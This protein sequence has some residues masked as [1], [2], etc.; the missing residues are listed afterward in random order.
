MKS[1]ELKT[2]DTQMTSLVMNGREIDLLLRKNIL[3]AY[4]DNF[5]GEDLLSSIKEIKN[6][7]SSDSE[8]VQ[9]ELFLF[10]KL[11][12]LRS[13]ILRVNDFYIQ[14]ENLDIN[15]LKNTLTNYSKAISNYNNNKKTPLIAKDF[16]GVS[17]SLTNI[18]NIFSVDNNFDFKDVYQQIVTAKVTMDKALSFYQD[19]NSGSINELRAIIN[20]AEDF[21]IQLFLFK[22]KD[23]EKLVKDIYSSNIFSAYLLEKAGFAPEEKKEIYASEKQ[24]SILLWI[25]KSYLNGENYETGLQELCA[26]NAE[27]Y[28]LLANYIPVDT[29]FNETS[30]TQFSKLQHLVLKINQSISCLYKDNFL[31]KNG[32]YIKQAI[33]VASKDFAYQRYNS[34]GKKEKTQKYLE[35]LRNLLSKKEEVSS[36]IG[37]YKKNESITEEELTELRGFYH[38]SESTLKIKQKE[39]KKDNNAELNIQT[40]IDFSSETISLIP[41]ILSGHMLLGFFQDDFVQFMDSINLDLG[42]IKLIFDNIINPVEPPEGVLD[43][44]KSDLGKEVLNNMEERVKDIDLDSDSFLANFLQCMDFT[45]ESITDLSAACGEEGIRTCL[46]AIICCT[47]SCFCGVCSFCCSCYF[48]RKL[49]KETKKDLRYSKELIINLREK[50]NSNLLNSFGNKHQDAPM[51]FWSMGD[52]KKEADASNNK[53]YFKISSIT[54]LIDYFN[55]GYVKSIG[56]EEIFFLD[57]Y[58]NRP[59]ELYFSKHS[60]DA[61]FDSMS[62][63]IQNH[64]INKIENIFRKGNSESDSESKIHNV[65][66]KYFNAESVDLIKMNYANDSV[67]HT[68]LT[69]HIYN[70]SFSGESTKSSN[71]DKDAAE[72]MAELLKNLNIFLKSYKDTRLIHDKMKDLT[73]LLKYRK[74]LSSDF[75]IGRNEHFVTQDINDVYGISCN[76][77]DNPEEKPLENLEN[78]ITPDNHSIYKSNSHIK[79]YYDSDLSSVDDNIMSIFKFMHDKAKTD[80]DVNNSKYIDIDESF[81]KSLK[82]SIKNSVGNLEQSAKKIIDL[83]KNFSEKNYFP[84]F[85]FSLNQKVKERDKKDSFLKE[86]GLF[87]KEAEINDKMHIKQSLSSSSVVSRDHTHSVINAYSAIEGRGIVVT[88]QPQSIGCF[89]KKPSLVPLYIQ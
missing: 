42:I 8:V 49:K 13:A 44:F 37:N 71:D 72:Y 38:L 64:C 56:Y 52:K 27:D 11:V 74:K 78:M 32:S 50:I 1:L 31:E 65:M 12:S 21:L 73:F 79:Y 58:G 63:F 85:Y 20:L 30:G 77:F 66:S 41:V 59:S 51:H 53:L 2:F 76:T 40:L 88:K 61:M 22:A 68:D 6:N 5:R 24:K 70:H 15:K 3:S 83:E 34:G 9:L 18:N 43:F 45:I 35:N 46:C 36:I 69:G 89:K 39:G 62:D 57:E 33:T 84:S 67:F 81:F 47:P 23:D 16:I 28:G 86:E 75:T 87:C 29:V 55:K 54:N 10:T 4:R 14:S 7:I 80:I 26:V 82:L 48:T 60:S 25:A 17:K 19:S